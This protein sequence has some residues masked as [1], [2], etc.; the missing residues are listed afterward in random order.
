LHP[1][2]HEYLT[3]EGLEMYSPKFLRIL[4][5]IQDS[6]NEGLHMLYSQFR[7]VEGIG[8]FQL[9][10]EAAGFAQFKIRKTGDT[11]EID[12]VAE[13]A[14]KPKFVLYTGTETKE[15]KEVILNIYNSTW[16]YIP[17]EM[18]AK[19]RERYANNHRGE[20]V[21]LLMI[22]SSGAEGINL[23]NT[24]FVHIMESYWNNVRIEQIIGRARR[25]CSHQDLPED[26]RTVK[27]F[28][29]V[30]KFTDEQKTND[31]NIEIMI[32]DISR[33]DGKTP[34]T[35]D[36]SLLETAQI[37]ERLN[38]QIL[39]AVKESAMDCNVYS[40]TNKEENLVCYGYG[41]VRS[42]QFGTYP[43]LEMDKGEKIEQNATTKKWKAR[44]ITD[45]ETGI[46]YALNEKTGEVYDLESYSAAKETGQMILV[47]NF[48]K[49]NNRGNIAY[50]IE[51]L[52]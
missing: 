10:L 36:Q 3:K 18:A 35:T 46:D 39:K 34:I 22:T 8:L 41:S 29:Y 27:V 38:F 11:W 2:P 43:T 37:K 20:I 7:T 42:N 14:D 45:D 17:P 24:R 23:R 16:D 32:N 15:E 4:E 19:L 9:V 52:K 5:N 44:K 1:R 47:G 21:K 31:K 6:E 50:R 25:I 26:M 48:V 30:M 40:G 28:M 49:Y 51:F 12:E 33:V 13:D